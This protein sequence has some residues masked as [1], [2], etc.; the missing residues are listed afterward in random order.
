MKLP[1]EYKPNLK[2]LSRLAELA[3]FQNLIYGQRGTAAL[4]RERKKEPYFTA[5]EWRRRKARRKMA[6]ASRRRNR[7][8]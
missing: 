1:W 2:F 7:A 6:R 3:I 4:P 5:K 8:S